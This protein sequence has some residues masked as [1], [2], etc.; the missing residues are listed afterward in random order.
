MCKIL[1]ENGCDV[2]IT[3]SSNKMAAHIAKKHNHNETF[4]YLNN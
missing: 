3:D 1:V 4:E 2:S